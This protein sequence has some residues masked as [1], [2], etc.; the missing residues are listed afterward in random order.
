[1]VHYKLLEK[2]FGFG[3]NLVEEKIESIKEISTTSKTKELKGFLDDMLEDTKRFG[4][5]DR[6]IILGDLTLDY[7]YSAD[8][9]KFVTQVTNAMIR[10][11]SYGQLSVSDNHNNYI[12]FTPDNTK[13]PNRPVIEIITEEDDGWKLHLQRYGDAAQSSAYLD[14]TIPAFSKLYLVKSK[15]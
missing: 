8:I 15:C 6:V 14:I 1:M 3:A 10:R 9:D 11:P 5:L 2:L 4:T 13:R 12:I 7:S